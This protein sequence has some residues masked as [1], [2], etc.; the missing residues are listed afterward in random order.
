MTPADQCWAMNRDGSR[1][2]EPAA[3]ESRYCKCH[4]RNG[5]PSP[6]WI[7]RPPPSETTTPPPAPT[8]NA[9]PLSHSEHPATGAMDST[10]PTPPP[11][12]G[13]G[14]EAEGRAPG[15]PTPAVPE[16]GLGAFVAVTS[17]P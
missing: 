4:G 7:W 16:G 9:T 12:R 1:C 6:L 8:A 11:L 3:A 10:A 17:V 2:A 13:R 5:G 15:A 14:C